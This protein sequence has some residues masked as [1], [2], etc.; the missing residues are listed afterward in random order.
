[1]AKPPHT[2]AAMRAFYPVCQIAEL[3][4]GYGYTTLSTPDSILM[5]YPKLNTLTGRHRLPDRRC[6]DIALSQTDFPSKVWFS[7]LRLTNLVCIIRFLRHLHTHC[8]TMCASF[9]SHLVR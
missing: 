1:M 9:A 5:C 7:G 6:D 4:A 3:A 2:R 8:G